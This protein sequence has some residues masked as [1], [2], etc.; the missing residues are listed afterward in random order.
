MRI[1]MGLSDREETQILEYL[2]CLYMLGPTFI[3]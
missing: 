2:L 3:I 1:A